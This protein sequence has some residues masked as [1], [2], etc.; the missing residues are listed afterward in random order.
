MGPTGVGKSSFI[1]NSVP[2]IWRAKVKIG[3]GL[4][5]KT[6]RVQSVRWATTDDIT[7]KLVDTPSFDDSRT[8]VTD[9]DVLEM[10]ATFLINRRNGLTGLIYVHRISDTRVGGNAQRNLRMFRNLCGDE[11]LKNVVI[12]TTM[13]DK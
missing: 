1:R 13:W 8:G 7:V 2:S 12:V 3:H 9:T 4:Q 10:I 6:N 5:S 11:S